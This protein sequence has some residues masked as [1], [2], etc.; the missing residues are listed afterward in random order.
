MDTVRWGLLPTANINRK[1][2]PAIPTP[3]NPH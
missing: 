3:L 2:I 1:V